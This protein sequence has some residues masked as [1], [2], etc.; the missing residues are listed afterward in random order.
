MIRHINDNNVRLA[1]EPEAQNI[2]RLIGQEVGSGGSWH[3]FWN[4]SRY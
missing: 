2:G 3:K 4:D 1:T